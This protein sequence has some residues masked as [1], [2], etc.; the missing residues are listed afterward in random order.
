MFYQVLI[1]NAAVPMATEIIRTDEGFESQF[2]ANH[3]GHFLLTSLLLPNLKE[4][5]N[6][7]FSSRVIN[8]SSMGHNFGAI[9][10]DDPNFKLRPEEYN[11][12]SGYAQ[13]K[14]ANILFSYEFAKRFES[15][16]IL[17]YSIHP[18]CVY[19]NTPCCRMC[20]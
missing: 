11:R 1:N 4:A 16:G 5:T 3:L 9:R 15:T 17:S 12:Y 14:T 2:G 13:S 18:G 19:H 7:G 20:H 10:F 6:G 8:A